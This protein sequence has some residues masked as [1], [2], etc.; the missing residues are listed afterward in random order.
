MLSIETGL[1][2]VLPEP[3]VAHVHSVAGQLVGLMSEKESGELLQAVLGSR[4]AVARVPPAA[5]GFQLARALLSRCA[6]GGVRAK[7]GRI[8]LWILENHGLAWA[9]S[10]PEAILAASAAFEAPLREK[11]SLRSYPAP[12]VTP[13]KDAADGERWYRVALVGW[14]ACEFDER[15]LFPDFVGHFGTEA[16]PGNWVRGDDRTVRIRSKPGRPLEDHV[17]V[18]YAHALVSTLSRRRG[19]YRPLPQPIVQTIREM[20]LEAR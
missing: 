13:T 12:V 11:F 16:G 3:W 9:A 17:Q 14:P 7:E 2:A 19:C 1:H 5:P 6:D 10:S 18:F 20:G 4:V 15:P 8:R